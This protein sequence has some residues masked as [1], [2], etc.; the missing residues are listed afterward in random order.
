VALAAKAGVLTFDGATVLSKFAPQWIASSE[1]LVVIGS[2]CPGERAC[3]FGGEVIDPI[4]ASPTRL[5]IR[6]PVDPSRPSVSAALATPIRV[7][8]LRNLRWL[9]TIPVAEPVVAATFNA[10][11]FRAGAS[12]VAEWGHLDRV[13][14]VAGGHIEEAELHAWR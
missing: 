4:A 13:A 3:E 1:V 2:P 10:Q 8:P 14:V 7:V 6:H 5:H 9:G 12:V 11:E